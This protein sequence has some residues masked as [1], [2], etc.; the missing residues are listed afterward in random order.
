MWP[1]TLKR[2]L[3][4]DNENVYDPAKVLSGTVLAF[5]FGERR[6]G[7]AVGEH[8]IRSANPLTTIDNESNEVRFNLITQLVNEWQPKLLVVGLPLSLDGTETEVTQLCKKFARRLNGRFNLPVVLID[9]RYSSVE[10]SQLLNQS[11]IKGRA[12]KVMLDQ[13]AAQTILQSYFDGLS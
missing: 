6:I 7:I 13:V 9:E 11:G 1:V 8:L 12:Q 10:A 2:M 5:D 4:I 3:V